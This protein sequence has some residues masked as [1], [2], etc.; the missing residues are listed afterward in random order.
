MNQ[1]FSS[2]RRGPCRMKFRRWRKED[3]KFLLLIIKDLISND[4]ISPEFIENLNK[5]NIS[6]IESDLETLKAS[7]S[8]KN[9]I[10]HLK[11]RI[12]KLFKPKELSVREKM[13]LK[14]ILKLYN[15]ESIDYE[16]LKT[17]FPGKS[18]SILEST[19]MELNRVKS[20]N[21]MLQNN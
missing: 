14:R 3:D 8:W 17:E 20:N 12:Q 1:V 11:K 19:C 10:S 5:P 6:N 16:Y 2:R 18:Q 15:N 13:K 4:M 7:I 21:M 9:P